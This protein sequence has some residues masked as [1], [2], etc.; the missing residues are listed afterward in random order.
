MEL[1]SSKSDYEY[2][3]LPCDV[4][5]SPN[6]IIYLAVRDLVDSF[7]EFRIKQ[8]SNDGRWPL[9]WAFGEN[10]GLRKLPTLYEAHR[11]M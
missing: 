6:N 11:T 2:V 3:H 4:I 10:E 5:D 9:G 1:N 8:Q 7:L